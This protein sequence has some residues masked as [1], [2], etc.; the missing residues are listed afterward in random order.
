LIVYMA[1]GGFW[2]ILA[3]FL[4]AGPVFLLVIGLILD[5]RS[6]DSGDPK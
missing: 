1:D 5:R 3:A 4:L 6:N 2:M